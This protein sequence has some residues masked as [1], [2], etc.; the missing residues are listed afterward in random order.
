MKAAVIGL[1]SMGQKHYK[2][3]KQFKNLDVYSV[4][5]ASQMS[6]YKTTQDLLKSQNEY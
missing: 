5:P 4:D 6:N 2:I 3:L 1:G